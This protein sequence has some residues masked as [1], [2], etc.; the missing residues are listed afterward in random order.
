MKKN[1]KQ[2]VFIFICVCAWVVGGVLYGAE[3]TIKKINTEK[4]TVVINGTASDGFE[5][6]I[7]VCFYNP[8]T[9]KR[10]TCGKI[11]KAGKLTATIKLSEKKI[12]KVQMNHT[13]STHTEKV[14]SVS[15]E[16]Q[17]QEGATVFNR[18]QNKFKVSLFYSYAPMSVVGIKALKFKGIDSSVHD[19]LWEEAGDESLSSVPMI[20]GGSFSYNINEL[21][22]VTLGFNYQLMGLK[23][24]LS[25]YQLIDRKTYVYTEQ[26]PSAF[27][28]HADFTAYRKY[29]GVTGN[30]INVLVGLL[31]ENFSSTF[32]AY[33]GNGESRV[34][35][36]EVKV[37]TVD[38]SMSVIGLRLGGGFDMAITQMFSMGASLITTVPVVGSPSYSVSIEN[39][40]FEENSAF[41]TGGDLSSDLESAMGAEK[42]FGIE[43]S[44]GASV[45]F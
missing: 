9:L 38:T 44:I 42:K 26:K 19:T 5:K 21:F 24:I 3:T 18:T 15:G 28:I 6:G 29:L 37:A 10:V 14:L 41:V 33:T 23:N 30:N 31:Y 13:V 11:R 34:E 40:D 4:R 39:E 45:S 17:T 12:A 2:I 22:S 32:E 36:E 16:S 43:I 1:V 25:D 7:K 35:S 27:A 20:F 8:D